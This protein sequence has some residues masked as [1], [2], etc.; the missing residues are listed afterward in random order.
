GVGADRALLVGVADGRAV[1]TAVV[2]LVAV[3]GLGQVRAHIVDVRDAVA[4]VVRIGAAVLVLEAVEI[5]G[6]VGALVDVVLDAITVPIAD[7]G[8]VLEPDEK[9]PPGGGAGPWIAVERNAP[10]QLEVGVFSQV[11]LDPGQGLGGIG[12]A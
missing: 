4:I 9:A 11:E 3:P 7:R 1:R 2:V 5:L 12:R 8:L 6:V 10:A